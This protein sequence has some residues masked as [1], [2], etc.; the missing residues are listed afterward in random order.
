MTTVVKQ[1]AHA[2]IH[3]SAAN[4][5]ELSG[6]NLGCP[7][8]HTPIVTLRLEVTWP[9]SPKRRENRNLRGK[10]TNAVLALTAVLLATAGTF[11]T[12]TYVCKLLTERVQQSQQHYYEPRA[13]YSDVWKW[14]GHK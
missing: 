4:T 2:V 14:Q 10:K 11:A 9:H 6:A 13:H 3:N 5:L 7:E 8:T 12:T 1:R